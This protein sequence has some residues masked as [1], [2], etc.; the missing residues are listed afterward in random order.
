MPAT[1]TN[2]K[3]PKCTLCSRVVRTNVGLVQHSLSTG[4]NADRC[5]Q[6]CARIFG[7]KEGLDAHMKSS[8]HT[9]D[10]SSGPSNK[11]SK[12]DTPKEPP[13]ISEQQ[14]CTTCKQRFQTKSQLVQ[15]SLDSGHG[16]D[17][18][19]RPCRRL[20]NTKEALEAHKQSSIRTRKANQDLQTSISQTSQQNHSLVCRGNNYR[21]IPQQD[22][23]GILQKLLSHCHSKSTLQR[24]GYR[25]TEFGSDY[26]QPGSPGS[27]QAT[28]NEAMQLPLPQSNRVR[29]IC[30]AVV[31]DCEMVGVQGGASELVSL[32]AVDFLTGETIVNSLV[33]PQQPV[34]DWRTQIHGISPAELVMAR[35]QGL[36]LDGWQAAR[37]ELF[38]LVDQNTIL[39][40]QSLQYDLDA[41]HIRH[42]HVVDSAILASEAVFGSKG[43]PRYWGLGLKDLC[44]GLLGLKIREGAPL[45][46]SNV[47]EGLED[48]LAAR[49]VV[50]YCMEQSIE[51]KTWA[52]GKRH[53]FW[54][55]PPRKSR[56]GKTQTRSQRRGP[57]MNEENYDDDEYMSD[58][59]LR[60]EDVIDWEMW[61]KS[62]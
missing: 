43:K 27:V 41:L 9:K 34:V 14:K 53:S 47:H 28:V 5:C 50:L 42:A 26:D 21:L 59:V 54:R 6:P 23:D 20:F 29:Q 18:C 57:R 7:T 3:G 25:L 35:A 2:F 36:T 32:T 31:L 51:F 15:H 16:E 37:A 55:A 62:P 39:I 45:A 13:E 30:K 46:A 8:V 24:H 33:K 56:Q 19:C 52:R 22:Q 38:K 12:V 44:S 48:V 10:S 1:P 17:R 40:G 11:S 49:E 4:H 61:P 60:W 58:E